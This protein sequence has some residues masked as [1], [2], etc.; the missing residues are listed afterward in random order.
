MLGNNDY[1]DCYWASAAHEVMAQAH[2][3][4]RTPT[5]STESVLNTYAVYLGLYGV[6]GL[7]ADTDKGTE[8]RAGAK[9]R[10]E[11]GVTDGHDHG[12]RIGA[13]VFEE[14]PDYE[15]LLSAIYDFGAVTLCFELPE[16]AEEAFRAYEEGRTEKL[17]WDLST[18]PILDG[19]AVAG[20]ARADSG[21]L[22]AVSWG[23]EVEITPAFVD[24]YLQCA[25]VYVSSSVLDGTGHAPDG[26][27][28]AGLL[29]A[30]KAV[31]GN[32]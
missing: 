21:Q 26:L 30:L 27:D 28:K 16:S 24:H 32:G 22:V 13:Y 19:H 20:V 9:F 14:T 8:P 15:K 10:R 25:L 5:F 29:E 7:N 31:K 6:A 18:T 1:G 23:Q 17:V 3:A 11:N 12:H 2:L 4:G